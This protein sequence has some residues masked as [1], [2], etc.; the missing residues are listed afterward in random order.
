LV[1]G[2]RVGVAGGRRESPT[3]GKPIYQFSY[4][5]R[6]GVETHVNHPYMDDGPWTSEVRVGDVPL[7]EGQSVTYLYDFGDR[8][9]FEVTL[10]RVD[11]PDWAMKEP[12]ILDARG[13]APEQYPS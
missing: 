5:N 1:P 11:P 7:Q 8:W 10:E 2:R 9:E 13:E 3:W 12:A 6:F 4:R